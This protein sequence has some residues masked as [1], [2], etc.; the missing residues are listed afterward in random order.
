[1][2]YS[3]FQQVFALSMASNLAMDRSGSPGKLQEILADGIKSLLNDNIIQTNMPGWSVVWG[4]C[5][6]QAELSDKCDQAMVVFSNGS[7]DVVAIAATNSASWYDW[8]IEDANVTIKQPVAWPGAPAGCWISD[9][10]L[11][12]I[13]RLLGMP[14]KPFTGPTLIDFLK[15]RPGADKKRTLIFTGHSLAGALSPTLPLLLFTKVGLDMNAWKEVKVYPSAGYSP[16]NDKFAAFFQS[17]FPPSNQQGGNSFQ[18]WNQLV[19]NTHDVVPRA[20]DTSTLT[21]L[22]TLYGNT[23]EPLDRAEIAVLQFTA[24]ELSGP[25]YKQLLSASLTQPVAHPVTTLDEFLQQ[26]SFQHVEAYFHLLGVPGLLKFM[27]GNGNPPPPS[28]I[29]ETPKR[30]Q[31]ASI[32]HA[33]ATQL[34]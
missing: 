16:G 7:T 17:K 14:F 11:I 1:M 30:I 32:A 3:D 2:S 24:H 15:D 10:T 5:V 22:T 34:S 27:P 19:W 23:L 8:L 21:G 13:D 4:P 12:G 31:A 20:W 29:A 28:A 18:V 9:G 26:M 6:W 25:D 33:M